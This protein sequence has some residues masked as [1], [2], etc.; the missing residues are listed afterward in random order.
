MSA[1]NLTLTLHLILAALY[2]PI[3]IT[4]LQRHA[5]HE[6]AAMW[7]SG[8][9]LIGAFLNVGEG[10][11]RGGRLDIASQ[12]IANDFQTYGAFILAF[13]LTLAVVSFV[14]R[15]LRA[16]LG[17][18]VFWIIGFLAIAFNVFRFQEVVCT[19]GRF[20][21]TYEQLLPYWAMLGW[22]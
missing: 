13:F 21:L 20:S 16:W 22:L 8:Y 17:V 5:G 19:N 3:L 7:L 18:G 2:L 14:R 4:L 9:I 11:W 6:T 12:Q 1:Q 10:L 15:D